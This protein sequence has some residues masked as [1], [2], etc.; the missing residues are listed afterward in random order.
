MIGL[1]G[2]SYFLFA[3]VFALHGSIS[4]SRRRRLPAREATERTPHPDPL[5]ARGEKEEA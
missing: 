2:Y 1:A 5:P 3:P 4:G